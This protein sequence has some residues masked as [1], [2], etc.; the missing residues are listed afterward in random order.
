M[1][2]W[3]ILLLCDPEVHAMMGLPGNYRLA[4]YFVLVRSET[5]VTGAELTKAREPHQPHQ[6]YQLG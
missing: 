2:T 6:P 5:P 4:Q 1:M 3:N